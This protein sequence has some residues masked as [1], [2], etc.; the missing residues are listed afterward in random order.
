LS[1]VLA[2]RN[3]VGLSANQLAGTDRLEECLPITR[4]QLSV[5]ANGKR[6][7]SFEKYGLDHTLWTVNETP[8]SFVFSVPTRNVLAGPKRYWFRSNL[9]VV[10]ILPS[11]LSPHVIRLL[12]QRSQWHTQ[13]EVT[14]ESSE[15]VFV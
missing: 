14:T 5:F 7:E 13:Q 9:R 1:L 10:S 8:L 2:M 6:E 11:D 12:A 15:A 3:T 4:R